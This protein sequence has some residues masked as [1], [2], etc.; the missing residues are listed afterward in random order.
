MEMYVC[1]SILFV[2]VR[3]DNSD[4]SA[5][6]TMLTEGIKRDTYAR[7]NLII[8]Y[9]WTS[10]HKG[11][12]ES[13]SNTAASTHLFNLINKKTPS[14]NSAIYIYLFQKR[15]AGKEQAPDIVQLQSLPFEEP[16]QGHRRMKLIKRKKY[17]CH[18][19]TSCLSKKK[20]VFVLVC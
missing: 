4:Q 12:H 14:H 11:F 7:F 16:P 8:F 17:T 9:A 10:Y 3:K 13:T 5:K 6:I 15:R 1:V 20:Q 18:F 19:V 2:Q